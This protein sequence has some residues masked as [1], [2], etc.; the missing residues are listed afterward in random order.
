MVDTER[1]NGVKLSEA[2]EGRLRRAFVA[3]YGLDLGLE[4]TAETMAW[5]WEHRSR[6]AGVSNPAGYLYRVGQSR[7]RRHLRW[8]RRQVSFPTESPEAAMP[9]VEPNLGTALA[10]LDAEQRTAVVLVHCFQ[11]TYAEVA[12]LLEVP[13][14][15]IRNHLHRGLN[16]LRS[17]LGVHDA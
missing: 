2:V 4:I 8:R 1:D 7:A 5:A 15:T 3:R 9:W 6:L 11:W 10:Q 16:R 17:L 12:E 13:H 14:H